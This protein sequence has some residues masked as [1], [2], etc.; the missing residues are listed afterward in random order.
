MKNSYKVLF[1]IFLTLSVYGGWQLQGKFKSDVS[2]TEVSPRLFSWK[3]GVTQY[4]DLTMNSSM[5]MNTTGSGMNQNMGVNLQAG[6]EMLT[7]E[8]EQNQALVGMQL[9]NVKLKVSGQSDSE[10]NKIL[11]TPF[12]VRFSSGGVPENFEFSQGLN[13]QE[14]L[15]LENVVRTFT[16][17]LVNDEEQWVSNEHNASGQYDAHYQKISST[18]IKKQKKNFIASP[19]SPILKNAVIV[20][21]ESIEVDPKKNWIQK[22]VVEETLQTK[23]SVGNLIYIVNHAEIIAAR[24]NR[25]AIPISH[26]EF[27]AADPIFMKQAI[28]HA[29][30]KMSVGEAQKKL[31]KHL[32][33]LDETLDKRTPEIHT[34]RDLLR[35][36]GSMPALLLKQMQLQDLSDRTRADLYLALELAATP[37]AQTALTS[38]INSPE[39]S[40][41]D[42]IRAIVALA[43]INN[44]SQETLVALWDTANNHEKN[45]LASTATFSLGSMGSRMNK[46]GHPEYPQLRDNLLAAA[47]ASSNTQQKAT[48]L[49]ALGNTRDPNVAEDISSFLVDE[50]AHVRRAAALSLGVTQNPNSSEVLVQQ[51]QQENHS[52][53]RGAIA[54][55]LT[56]LPLSDSTIA[57][58]A[59]SKA[60]QKE[61]D[62]KARYSMALF[63]GK[64]LSEHPQYRSQLQNLIRHEPSK[65]VRQ[66]AAE[67]LATSQ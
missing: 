67:A 5:S 33:K 24:N 36:D 31:V 45:Q 42:A 49:Y 11:Q 39:W 56:A 9:S 52:A 25:K 32:P 1:G 18:T 29:S 53:V 64:H 43:G 41:R 48:Y 30:L 62:E 61:K 23:A 58:Q 8:S 20:S 59:V 46:H 2:Q 44:P 55:S 60:L 63:I 47:Y 17:S 4:Y 12:R 22:M 26:W 14:Q 66:V 15:M 37:E 34:L 7:L 54:E 51:F 6:L 13:S 40:E 38:I 10:V 3:T 65:R 21:S 28:Q 50:Q 27:E 57:M 19:S 35:I 16:V